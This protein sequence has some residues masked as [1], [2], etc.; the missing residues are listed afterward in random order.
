M[1]MLPRYGLK[2]QNYKLVTDIRTISLVAILL[3]ILQNFM[4]ENMQDF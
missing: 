1:Q 4:E 2:N 3:Y